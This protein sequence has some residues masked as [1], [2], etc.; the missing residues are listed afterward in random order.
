MTN[1]NTLNRVF[2]YFMYVPIY[3]RKEK[4]LSPTEDLG[5]TSQNRE[6]SH[7]KEIL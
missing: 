6:N 2:F 4:I 3:H 1:E 5:F 7:G